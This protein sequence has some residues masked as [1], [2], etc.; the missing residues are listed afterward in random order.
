MPGDT[1]PERIEYFQRGPHQINSALAVAD[2]Q[3]M[4]NL[5]G[6]IAL[7]SRQDHGIYNVQRTANGGSIA[8][9]GE[10]YRLATDA[11]QG[12]S[13]AALETARLGVYRSGISNEVAVGIWIDEPPTGD[14][15]VRM[16]YGMN[17]ESDGVYHV[18]TADDWYVAFENLNNEAVEVSRAAGEW[19]RGQVTEKRDSEGTLQGRVYGLD[20][21]TG[22]EDSRV[23]WRRGEGYVYGLTIGWYGPLSTLAW[24]D[25]V[26][27]I[28]GRWAQRRLPLFLY[29]PVQ[30]PSFTV[31][32]R[33]IHV[34][35]DNGTTAEAV[36]ARVGGRQYSI[37]GD[38][39]PSPEPTFASATDVSVPMDGSG[40]GPKDWFPVALFRRKPDQSGAAVGLEDVSFSSPNESLALHSR[41]IE[42][43]YLSGTAFEGPDDVAARQ[44]ALEFDV[45]SDTSDRVDVETWTDPDDGGKVKP[46]GM[47]YR[48]DHV[49][50]GGQFEATTGDLSGDLRFPV[51]REVPTVI[52][53]RTRTATGDDVDVILKVQ[54]VGA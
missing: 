27:D 9:E 14:G 23:K 21:L 41:V 18:I 4:F 11:A 46:Q 12:E 34:S 25:A 31:P 20:P 24:I 51:V 43:Q 47:A 6:D 22:G 1:L 16:G 17:T 15:E 44:T 38:V 5:K 40:V 30:D 48:G 32:N 2:R 26:G 8:A 36:E 42:S 45:K 37:Q 29:R 39:D 3:G 10:T 7:P 53:A 28:R 50:A 13:E 19:E 33:P 54:E 49:G 35:V 52:F